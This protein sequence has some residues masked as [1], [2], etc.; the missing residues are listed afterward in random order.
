MNLKLL[1]IIILLNEYSALWID[2]LIKYA[3]FMLTIIVLEKLY[4]IL[5]KIIYIVIINKSIIMKIQD[6]QMKMMI[7]NLQLEFIVIAFLRIKS[8]TSFPL[9]IIYIKSIILYSKASSIQIQL[10]ASGVNLKDCL[11]ILYV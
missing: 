6:L 11:I 4:Y 8:W 5:L 7:I 3:Y 9:G 1:H 10:K 2:L